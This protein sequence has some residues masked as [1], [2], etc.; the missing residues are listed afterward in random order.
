MIQEQIDKIKISDT[1][2]KKLIQ[3]IEEKVEELSKEKNYD[4][5]LKIIDS[6]CK[7]RNKYLTYYWTSYIGY[8]KN[9]KDEKYLK[10][11][12][13]MAKYEGPYNNSVYKFFE[14]I[15]S[16]KEK[17]HIINKYGKRF[18]ELAHNQK[19]LKSNEIK[20]F[21]EEKHLRKEYRKILNNIRI[22][23]NNEEIS[24]V[25]LNKYFI[26]EDEQLRKEA[27]DKSYEAIISVTNE[28][29]TIFNNLLKVRKE[30]AKSTN[31]KSYTDY[32][33]IKM[34]RVD[35]T[36]KDL[37][38]FKEGIVKYFTPLREKLKKEQAKRLNEKE[39]SYY[40]ASY[41]FNDGNAK[42]NKD[43]DE[44]LKILE[45][46]FNDINPEYGKLFRFMLDNN[47]I[48]LED[49]ENKSAGGITTYIPD[50]QVP[51]FIKRYMDNS[52]NLIAITHEFGHSLQLYL[53]KDKNLHENRWPT[54]DICEI[55]S[56]TMELLVSEHISKIYGNDT[57]KHLI[58]HYTNLIDIL[59][60]TSA[61][62]DFKSIIYNGNI[63]D[64]KE[65]NE[66]WKDIYKKYYPT[67]NYN[68]EYFNKGIMWQRDINRIDDP[69]YGIDYALATIYALSFYQKYLED[70]EEGIK[71][72][73]SFCKDG[74]EISFKEIAHKYHLLS[75]FNEDDLLILSQFLEKLL[76]KIN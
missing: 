16:I 72:F 48:D 44:L 37:K 36:E 2:V 74:G 20:L 9:I 66:V 67:N 45:S 7:D 6:I 3:N 22:N 65:V 76:L 38:V 54:F 15:D 51:I 14:V 34:N 30:I 69:F 25:K 49:R 35:Y 63:K 73:T 4:N 57:K 46:I 21:E 32:S 42:T 17:N 61:V 10:S 26:S 71:S 28:L 55:H 43:L 47:L 60:R 50:L 23:F 1:K 64:T 70:K 68:L 56:T 58:T 18:I 19:I 53:N 8:L 40:N 5:Q 29:E 75:P 13:I 52:Q 33:Y 12:D 31:I 39:L 62:D 24:L 59:I 11:E 41:L 27:Y